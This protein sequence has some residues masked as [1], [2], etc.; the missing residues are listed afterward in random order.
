M[1]TDSSMRKKNTKQSAMIWIQHLLNLQDINF[2]NA[3]QNIKKEKKKMITTNL[4][5][6]IITK[7]H[8]FIFSYFHILLMLTTRLPLNIIPRTLAVHFL[9]NYTIYQQISSSV[10][11]KIHLH[12][13][14]FCSYLLNRLRYC[15]DRTK[16][17]QMSNIIYT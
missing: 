11:F 7:P 10:S 9:W 14:F 2:K 16:F 5:Y 1:Q 4:N 3:K 8:T 17:H 12:I 13:F 6:Q 15:C